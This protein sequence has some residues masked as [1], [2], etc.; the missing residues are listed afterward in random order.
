M[1][2]R[3]FPL[4][5]FMLYRWWLAPY[6]T[7]C[8]I[9]SRAIRHNTR[10]QCQCC[11]VDA[12]CVSSQNDESITQLDPKPDRSRSLA[13]AKVR[14][15]LIFLIGPNAFGNWSSVFSLPPLTQRA[16]SICPFCY[17]YI[18]MRMQGCVNNWISVKSH[19]SQLKIYQI[20]YLY[21]GPRIP[22][23]KNPNTRP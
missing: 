23:L 4:A 8:D 14:V 15:G 21:N 19:A 7:N 3:N 17:S 13:E 11:W 12:G 6:S 1:E 18:P 20:K 10:L 5:R 2:L 22:N 16:F 9:R